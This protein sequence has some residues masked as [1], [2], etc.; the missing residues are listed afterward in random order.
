M[1]SS[2]LGA[3]LLQHKVEEWT[4]G[5]ESLPKAGPELVSKL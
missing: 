4:L 3:L 1:A 2:A 5:A